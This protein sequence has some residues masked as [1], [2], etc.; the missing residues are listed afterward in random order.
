MTAKGTKGSDI[1]PVPFITATTATPPRMCTFL[2]L[3]CV[4]HPSITHYF[5]INF[6]L[7]KQHVL[8]RSPKITKKTPAI[9]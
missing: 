4:F 7:Y 8:L 1:Q 6:K 2:S 5:K 9:P 3:C